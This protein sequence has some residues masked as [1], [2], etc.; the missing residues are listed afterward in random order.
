MLTLASSPDYTGKSLKAASSSTIPASKFSFSLD[1]PSAIPLNSRESYVRGW[2]VPDNGQTYIIWLVVDGRRIPAFTG[3]ARPDV[4]RHHKNNPA[5]LNPGFLVRFNRPKSGATVTLVATTAHGEIILAGGIPVPNFGE[6]SEPGTD[7]GYRRWLATSESSLF[8]PETEIPKRLL[9]LSYQPLISILLRIPEAHPY[10]VTRSVESV[11]QQRYS[12]W[13][14]CIAAQPSEYLEKIAREDARILLLP[15]RPLDAATGDFVISLDYRDELHPFALLEIVR[16]LNDGEP[17]N[18]VYADEDEMDFHGNRVRLL[19]K[20][21]F[22]PE[23]L[24]SWNVIGHMAA[25][26]RSALLET[27]GSRESNSWDTLFRVL[28]IP[29]SPP[30]RHIPKPLYHFRRGHETLAPLPREE[31]GDVSPKPILDHLARDGMT[32]IVERGLF[33]RSFRLLHEIRPEWRIAVLIRPE[34]SAFQ[35]AALAGSVD[36]RTT[37]IYELPA[38]RS[39]DEMPEDIFVFINRPVETLN[40]RF[41]EE[42][43][44]QAMRTDCGLVTGISL[45]RTGRVLH[46]PFAGI[47]FSQHEL[48]RDILVVRLVDAI[49]GDFFAVKRAQIVS[50]GGLEAA[51][52]ASMSELANNTRVLVTPYAVATFDVGRDSEPE[53]SSAPA[54]Q[55]HESPA[56]LRQQIQEL[57]AALKSERR[58]IAEIRESHS[59]KLTRPLRAFLRIARGKP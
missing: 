15:E 35:H 57:Q 20:P 50:L 32:A 34:D 1:T 26:R 29:G 51:C 2:F 5:F 48:L 25:V 38:M 16:A 6:V 3:L 14:L 56:E 58:A 54:R 13:Q 42:L 30:P 41:F 24:Q 43:A 40:H 59:W 17:P 4:V 27:G 18:L 36:R 46:E 22:D 33:P 44:A 28:E 9:S 21:D 37:R 10:L 8:W 11:L 12:R 45:D 55:R 49:S 39:L 7:A 52:R 47:H 53:P 23:A 31:D 19:A